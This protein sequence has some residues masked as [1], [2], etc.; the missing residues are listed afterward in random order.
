MP[1]VGAMAPAPDDMQ[2]LYSHGLQIKAAASERALRQNA[3]SPWNPLCSLCFFQVERTTA[4]V[5]PCNDHMSL[6]DQALLLLAQHESEDTCDEQQDET[7]SA[8]HQRHACTQ[9]DG[10]HAQP[11]VHYWN[12][13]RTLLSRVTQSPRRAILFV[14]GG[15]DWNRG[16][17]VCG[18]LPLVHRLS[19]RL[20]LPRQR[21]PR[22][23]GTTGFSWPPRWAG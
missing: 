8:L 1:A 16:R 2:L 20:K 7:G 23:L 19:L 9:A 18:L 15:I 3:V 21:P 12:S 6:T 22:P 11:G 5:L 13:L 17:I 4:P 14:A 10:F